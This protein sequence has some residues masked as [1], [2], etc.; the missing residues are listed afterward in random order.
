MDHLATRVAEC[1]D[2]LGASDI[3][4]DYA[5]R[6]RAKSLALFKETRDVASRLLS[7]LQ[8]GLALS[9]TRLAARD[10]ARYRMGGCL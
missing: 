6:D 3:W 4:A 10:A 8:A 7:S 2:A 1:N 9:P 5:P